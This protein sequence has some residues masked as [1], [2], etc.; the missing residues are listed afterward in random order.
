MQGNAVILCL[1]ALRKHMVKMFD[2]GN[3]CGGYVH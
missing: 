3:L 2:T 1:K